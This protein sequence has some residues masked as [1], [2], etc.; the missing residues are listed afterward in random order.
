MGETLGDGSDLTG[1]TDSSVGK[2]VGGSTSSE[3][4]IGVETDGLY[5]S[6]WTDHIAGSGLTSRPRVPQIPAVP[7]PL[8]ATFAPTN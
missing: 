1:L 3:G 2:R 4:E 5:F 7:A 8:T 6:L